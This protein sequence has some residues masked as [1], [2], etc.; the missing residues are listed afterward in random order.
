[1]DQTLNAYMPHKGATASSYYS[2][3]DLLSGAKK[4]DPKEVGQMFESMFYQMILKEMRQG[5]LSKGLFDSSAM[6]MQQEMWDNELAQKLGQRGD[7]GIVR[8]V[9]EYI[10]RKT[11]ASQP[12][13]L[14]KGE[15]V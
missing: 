14:L 5:E 10:E 8:M 9:E 6:Q 4:K 12:L 2:S 1:M 13:G 7:L 15:E 11:T 3:Q